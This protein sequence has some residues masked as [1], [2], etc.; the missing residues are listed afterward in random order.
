M[1]ILCA[2]H[3]NKMDFGGL[4]IVS[5]R[6]SYVDMYVKQCCKFFPLVRKEMDYFPPVFALALGFALANRM[7][8]EVKDCFAEQS[9]RG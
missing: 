6:M 3:K 7:C 1:A 2:Q 4:Y 5:G 8:S 9:L